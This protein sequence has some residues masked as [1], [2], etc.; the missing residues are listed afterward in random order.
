MGEHDEVEDIEGL[1]RSAVRGDLTNATDTVAG[2][3][4]PAADQDDPT[5]KC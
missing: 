4:T 5:T 1:L 3:P 2:V